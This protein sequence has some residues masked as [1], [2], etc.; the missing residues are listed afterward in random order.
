MCEI[1]E[2]LTVSQSVYSNFLQ[3]GQGRGEG[4]KEREIVW[5]YPIDLGGRNW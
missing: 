5:A 3:K 1:L 2:F 4:R